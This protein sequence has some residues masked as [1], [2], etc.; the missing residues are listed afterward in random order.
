MSNAYEDYLGVDSDLKYK[1]DNNFEV[2]SIDD[3]NF[4]INKTIAS[5]SK[6]EEE[7]NNMSDKIIKSGIKSDKKI[8]SEN[9]EFKLEKISKIINQLKIK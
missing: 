3:I 8:I 5:G 2:G 9:E 4:S 1:D 6:K 7:N